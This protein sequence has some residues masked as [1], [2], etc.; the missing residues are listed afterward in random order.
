M[1]TI[2]ERL[3]LSKFRSQFHLKEKEK[4]YIK[5]KGINKIQ[6][7]A[8]DF[9]EKRLA[10]AN[11]IHDGKQTPMKGHPVFIA[12]H[13]TATCCRGCLCKWHHIL[14]NHTL[15]QKEKDYIVQVIM[16]WIEKEMKN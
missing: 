2:L 16:S 11:P 8:Y 4:N 3:E 9:V 10:P 13:A 7:H 6:E 15:N 14:P 5:A 12:Q 1:M